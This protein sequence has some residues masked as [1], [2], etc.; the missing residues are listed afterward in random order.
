MYF[1]I[2]SPSRLNVLFCFGVGLRHF[3]SRA[4]SSSDRRGTNVIPFPSLCCGSEDF[5]PLWLPRKWALVTQVWQAAGCGT[6]GWDAAGVQPPPVHP[7]R[8]NSAFFWTKAALAMIQGVSS[9]YSGAVKRLLLPLGKQ[10][11]CLGWDL[12]MSCRAWAF[13]SGGGWI[14]PS[15]LLRVRQPLPFTGGCR[16]TRH[17]KGRPASTWQAMSS[18]RLFK[19]QTKSSVNLL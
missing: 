8:W 18:F 10:E 12:G 13:C 2:N 6:V 1:R 5:P 7:W 16:C 14:C 15:C 19:M 4:S 11:F 9:I 17:A 3:S